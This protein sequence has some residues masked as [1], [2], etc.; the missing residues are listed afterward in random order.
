MQINRR[1][2]IYDDALAAGQEVA[3]MWGDDWTEVA[4]MMSISAF[5]HGLACGWGAR[6]MR[7]REPTS[8]GAV[9]MLEYQRDGAFA[10]A[11]RTSQGNWEVGGRADRQTWDRLIANTRNW[12]RLR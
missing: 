8:V 1:E 6:E 4:N 11:M 12:E 2:Q 5:K 3:E 10:V 9:V 7:D